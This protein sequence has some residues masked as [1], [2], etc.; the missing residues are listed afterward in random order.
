MKNMIRN[1]AIRVLF[2]AAIVAVVLSCVSWEAEADA[3][4]YAIVVSTEAS[5]TEMY[6]AETLQ[7]YLYMLNNI[8]YHAMDS[9]FLVGRPGQMR[10]RLN[11]FPATI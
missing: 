4:E 5:T 1:R 10:L 6:A 9:A 7:E 8:Y 3:D 2:L 11:T